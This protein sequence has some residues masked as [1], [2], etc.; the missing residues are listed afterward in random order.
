VVAFFLARRTKGSKGSNKKTKQLID[1]YIQERAKEHTSLTKELAHLDRLLSEKQ[2]D[3]ETYDRLK[4]V[5]VTMK[6]KKS[7]D[8][9]DLFTYVAE[10]KEPKKE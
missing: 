9:D 4:N 3:K 5:L 10:K 2:I 1:S 7:M 8:A 6:G